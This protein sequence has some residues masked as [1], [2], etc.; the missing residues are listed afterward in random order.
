MIGR[1][2]GERLQRCLR[3]LLGRAAPLVYVDSQSSDGSVAFARSLGVEVV[4][5]DLSVPFTAARA[6]NEGFAR[7][8]SLT[9]ERGLDVPFVQFVDGDCEV[10]EG[11]VEAACDLLAN[12]PGLVAVTGVRRE[13]YPEQTIFNELCDVEWQM[14]SYGET[15]RFGGDVMIRA[16]ALERVGGYNPSVIAA[17]DDE[18]AVR[19]HEAGGRILRINRKM[20]VHD[21][22]IHRLSQWWQR[23]KRAGHGYAQVEHLHGAPPTNKFRAEKKRVLTWGLG[24]PAALLALAPPSIGTSLLLAGVYPLRALRVARNSRR[25]G[26]SPRASAAWGLSCAF[27]SFPE[28]VGMAKYHVDRLF[29]RAPKIIE[30]KGPEAQ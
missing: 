28:A 8:R 22:A 9:R 17:E 23:A 10:V 15:D 18:L 21:A 29:Q 14:G 26:M 6:R 5:L 7:L 19:L 3:S 30:Y 4:E 20:T 16:D 2:E 27:S 24:V 25:E 13:R 1:N 12:D 11:W